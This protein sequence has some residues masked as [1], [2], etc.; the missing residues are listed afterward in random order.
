MSRFDGAEGERHAGKSISSRGN[1]ECKDAELQAGL[2]HWR[3]LQE[4]SVA[5]VLRWGLEEA[6]SERSDHGACLRAL[7][8]KQRRDVAGQAENRRL[9]AKEAIRKGLW[10]FGL[11]G[12][13]VRVGRIT[14]QALRSQ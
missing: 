5:G 11:H 10:A 4:A 1:S 9:G 14:A 8:T 2:V 12:V 3:S 7:G 6:R 13:L